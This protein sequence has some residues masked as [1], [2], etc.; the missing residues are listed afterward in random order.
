MVVE[1]GRCT[2][3]KENNI[4]IWNVGQMGR[5]GF[6]RL[7]FVWPW[8][9]RNGFAWLLSL[10]SGAPFLGL[11]RLVLL[12]IGLCLYISH[13]RV[14]MCHLRFP[15]WNGWCLWR[16]KPWQE[17]WCRRRERRE[18]CGMNI[19]RIMIFFL[20][21]ENQIGSKAFDPDWFQRKSCDFGELG[22]WGRG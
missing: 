2:E 6:V 21:G 5:G 20:K 17:W 22:S 1:R 16:C 19:I 10:T 18:F 7:S 4:K 13:T 3:E 12:P 11:S 14:T 8:L 9:R 15:G